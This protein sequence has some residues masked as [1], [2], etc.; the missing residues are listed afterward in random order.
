MIDLVGKK[1]GKLT[2]ISECKYN[3]G[4]RAW[5]CRCDCGNLENHSYW[6][7]N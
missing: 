4:G 5:I 1:F 7:S 3:K 2:D 6:E